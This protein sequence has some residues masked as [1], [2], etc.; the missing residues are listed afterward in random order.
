MTEVSQA[1]EPVRPNRSWLQVSLSNLLALVL[2]IG[3]GLG[4]KYQFPQPEQTRLPDPSNIRPGQK[5][6]IEITGNVPEFSFKRRALVLADGTITLPGV[7]QV[8]AAG[9]SLDQLTDDLTQRYRDLYR[10]RTVHPRLD[11]V[12]VSFEDSSVTD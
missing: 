6:S 2:G 12:F 10:M 4:I 11:Q 9:L 5:I 3:I 8:P 7:R 1:T